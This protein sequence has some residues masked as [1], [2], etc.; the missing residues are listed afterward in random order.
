MTAAEIAKEFAG[1]IGSDDP[2]WVAKLGNQLEERIEALVA[3]RVLSAFHNG[4]RMDPHVYGKMRIAELENLTRR[5]AGALKNFR[6]TIVTF[7]DGSM[8][9][10]Y[11]SFETLEEVDV[12]LASIPAHLLAK[13]PSTSPTHTEATPEPQKGS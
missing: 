1:Y 11:P 12:A 3:E 13:E 4:M 7:P 10:A 8:P 5:L 6:S 2:E 9:R